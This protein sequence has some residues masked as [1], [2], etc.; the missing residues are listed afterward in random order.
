[1]KNKI[2]NKA[3]KF[4][5]ENNHRFT[6]PRKM[7]LEIISSSKKPI[8]AYDILKKLSKALDKDPKPPTIYRAIDF[9]RSHNFIHRV[10]SLNAYFPCI[11]DHLHQGSQFMICDECGTVI[12][13][14]FCDLPENI[15]KSTNKNSFY[16]KKWNLEI[17]GLCGNCL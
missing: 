14:H 6:E 4:C 16:P 1:M 13:A 11:A 2:T 5:V 12:E 15:K 17:N 7:V 10:E 9:W 8:K 3:H